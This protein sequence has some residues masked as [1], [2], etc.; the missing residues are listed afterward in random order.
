MKL[1]PKLHGY[2]YGIVPDMGT[3]IGIHHFFLKH[4][5]Y[6]GYWILGMIRVGV[7]ELKWSTCAT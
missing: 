3:G 6:N 7:R 4:V 1:S 2:E 5:G